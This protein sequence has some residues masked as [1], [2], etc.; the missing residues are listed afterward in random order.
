MANIG[1]SQMTCYKV[2]FFKNLQGSDGH[3]VKGLQRAIDIRHARSF[4]RAVKAA[5]REYEHFHHVAYWWLH[6]DF[7]E[8]EINGR[9]IDYHPSPVQG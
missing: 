2:S 4:D 9:K 5:E 1:E 3:P 8:V 6:A 7:F